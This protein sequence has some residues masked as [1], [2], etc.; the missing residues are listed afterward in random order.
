MQNS[1]GYTLCK[2]DI[3]NNPSVDTGQNV[4]NVTF[5]PVCTYRDTCAGW[6]QYARIQDKTIK[7]YLP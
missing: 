1:T 5:S 3:Q 7:A 6:F 2:V 4:E